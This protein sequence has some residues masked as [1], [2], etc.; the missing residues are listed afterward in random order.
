MP[1]KENQL[2]PVNNGLIFFYPLY[3]IKVKLLEVHP[4]EG[5]TSSL[6]MDTIINSLKNRSKALWEKLDFYSIKKSVK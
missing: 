4:V 6:I 2:T 5:K 3:G 1:Q